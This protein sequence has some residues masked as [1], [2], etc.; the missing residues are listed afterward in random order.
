VASLL[1]CIRIGGESP[2]ATVQL[3]FDTVRR[4]R[5]E[6]VYIMDEKDAQVISSCISYMPRLLLPF[7]VY[8]RPT[9]LMCDLH[10]RPDIHSFIH[11]FIQS[12]FHSFIH[13]FIHLFFCLTTG[14]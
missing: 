14:P 8:F 12:C 10:S 2:A 9:L 13:S 6:R 11:S 5:Q 1:S 7:A 4:D 3:T